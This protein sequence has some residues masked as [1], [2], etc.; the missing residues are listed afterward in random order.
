MFKKENI[1]KQIYFYCSAAIVVV[2]VS[3]V[4]GGHRLIQDIAFYKRNIPDQICSNND[5]LSSGNNDICIR[6]QMINILLK[7]GEMPLA[8]KKHTAIY[9][10]KTNHHYWQWGETGKTRCGY[11]P[12]IIPL[13]TGIVSLHGDINRDC[14]RTI[15]LLADNLGKYDDVEKKY[16]D[17]ELCQYAL[18][19]NL[20]QVFVLNDMSASLSVRLVK[21]EKS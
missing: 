8:M 9:V 5:R 1:L 15:F 14:A 4:I 13:F 2:L 12:F 7:L 6:R 11:V 21:C 3:T 17:K 18:S 16:T 20:L 10:P 19:Q